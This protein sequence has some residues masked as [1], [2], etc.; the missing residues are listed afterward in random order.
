MEEHEISHADQEAEGR[1]VEG[2]DRVDDPDFDR[3]ALR[4]RLEAIPPDLRE[5]LAS[6]PGPGW[7]WWY[8]SSKKLPTM[9][10]WHYGGLQK[11]ALTAKPLTPHPDVP[12][13]LRGNSELSIWLPA[14][15]SSINR[16]TISVVGSKRFW[17]M[18]MN[19]ALDLKMSHS[20]YE[21]TMNIGE[22]LRMLMGVLGEVS[23]R[24]LGD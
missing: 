8:G 12:V 15:P 9:Q 20:E 3:R 14:S 22:A 7:L 24:E 23:V 2:A 5:Q 11:S 17:R 19:R 21:P 18:T 10:K 4:R 13:V 6:E 1:A 16:A